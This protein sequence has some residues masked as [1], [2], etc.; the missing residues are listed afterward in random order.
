MGHHTDS[1]SR[2]LTKAILVLFHFDSDFGWCPL[3]FLSPRALFACL[4]N[5]D[6]GR[7]SAE[8]LGRGN[9]SVIGAITQQ[10]FT[11]TLTIIV[12]SSL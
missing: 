6:N 5:G 7:R 10:A 11:V 4:W 2:L 12:L 8:L 9:V 3:T 1:E